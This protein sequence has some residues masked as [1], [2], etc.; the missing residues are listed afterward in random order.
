[1]DGWID[2][3]PVY[4]SAMYSCTYF[5]KSV[6]IVLVQFRDGEEI[7]LGQLQLLATGNQEA[8]DGCLAGID[9]A[10]VGV[11]VVDLEEFLGTQAVEDGGEWRSHTEEDPELVDGVIGGSGGGASLGVMQE[12][13]V[14]VLLEVGDAGQTLEQVEAGLVEG[15][16]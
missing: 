15:D 13:G 16:D 11:G 12:F 14:E 7:V 10:K 2:S 3:Y 4:S 8:K 6:G 5:D 9:V 1:M